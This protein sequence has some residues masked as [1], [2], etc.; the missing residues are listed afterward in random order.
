MELVTSSEH[1]EFPLENL[2]FPEVG[3]LNTKSRPISEIQSTH[4]QRLIPEVARLWDTTSFSIFPLNNCK[5]RG[6]Q[7]P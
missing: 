3:V 4:M 2:V 5:I 6:C 1:L 7:G